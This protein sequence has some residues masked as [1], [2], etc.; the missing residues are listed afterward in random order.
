MVTVDLNLRASEEMTISIEYSAIIDGFNK[1]GMT[2][3]SIT[4]GTSLMKN[5]AFF[6]LQSDAQPGVYIITI[7]IKDADNNVIATYLVSAGYLWRTVN[8]DSNGGS[9]IHPIDTKRYSNGDVVN[10]LFDDIPSRD[11]YIFQDGQ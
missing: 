8:Y 1:G 6:Y 4:L 7:I 9:S 10:V 3:D 2:S 11:G 5:T